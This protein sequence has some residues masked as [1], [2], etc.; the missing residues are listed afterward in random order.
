MQ[1]ECHCRAPRGL[2]SKCIVFSNQ[3]AAGQRGQAAIRGA[4]V[5][6]FHQSGGFRPWDGD[7]EVRERRFILRFIAGPKTLVLIAISLGRIGDLLL[8]QKNSDQIPS[9]T[10]NH[11][12]HRVSRRILEA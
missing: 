7:P 4:P 9:K 1:A 3:R 12:V 2:F 6:R 5:A 10:L 8:F 11:G